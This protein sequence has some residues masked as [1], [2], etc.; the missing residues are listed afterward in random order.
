MKTPNLA[1]KSFVLFLILAGGMAILAY[2]YNV[3]GGK[4]P[5]SE[6]PYK[7]T[8][9]LTD[10]QQVLKH[11]DVRSAGVQVGEVGSIENGADGRVKM[12]L[13]IQKKHAP[14]FR[15]AKI[16][17]RQKTLV[18]ENYIDLDPGSAKASAIP[19]GGTLAVAAQKEAVPI[20]KVLN[21]LNPKTRKNV[22]KNFQSLGDAT[23]GRGQDLH[24]LFDRVAPLA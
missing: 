17:V 9:V 2:F 13:E 7:V 20:D 4:L 24:E 5:L 1:A 14:I 3:A 12:V 6:N 15:D 16:L 23:D 8:A 11:A 19:D 10:P 21:T 18:G 22:S